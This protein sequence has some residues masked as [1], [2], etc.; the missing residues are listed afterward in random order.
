V[1]V[2][3]GIDTGGTFTDF[4]VVHEG[5][6]FVFKVPST[7]DDPARAFHEGLA[8]A[9][10][11]L[12][13]AGVDVAAT[14]PW[15]VAHGFTVAT[16]ALL[17]RKGARIAFV[18]TQGF[19]DV[20]AIGRQHRP[21]LY[22]LAPARPLPLVAR[23]AIVG[24]AERLGP[25]G[26][27]LR[28]LT[29]AGALRVARAVARLKPEAVAVGFL[30]SYASDRHERRVRAA[31]ARVLPGVPVSLSSQVANVHREVERLSTTTADAYVAPLVTRYLRRLAAPKSHALRIMQSNGG[32]LPARET[33]RRPVA[34][35]LSGPAGGVLGAHRLGLRARV[36]SLL[37]LD[38]G[39]TSTDVALV[40]GR[41]LAT[42]ETEIAGIPLAVPILDVHTVGAGGGSIARV[43]AGG[44]LVVGPESAGAAP[45]P[46]CYGRGGPATVTD[47]MVVLGRIVPERFLDGGMALDAS[48]S[49]RVMAALGRKLGTD[50][51]GAARGVVAVAN[52]TIERALRAI[53][54]ERGHDVRGAALVA[55]GGAGPLHACELAAALGAG[56]VLVPPAA[57]ILSAW[58]LLGADEVF[59]EAATLLLRVPRSS[60]WPRAVVARAIARL[61]RTLVSRHGP[62]GR[63]GATFSLRYQGQSFELRLP[64][65]VAASDLRKAFD[66]AHQERYGYARPEAAVEIV[67]IELALTRP[68]PRLPAFPILRTTRRDALLGTH[69]VALARGA[70]AAPVWRRESLGRSFAARGPL[71]VIEYGATTFVPPGWRVRVDA[72]AN[73]RLE[74]A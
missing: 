30:H 24:A 58:G 18:T 59:A 71:L 56:E 43:D 40:P 46:A 67:E 5:S 39:G 66:R 29:P 7:P 53:S 37:T 33:A 3:V 1:T 34:T 64:A 16:N 12:L 70:R 32:A 38:I 25:R 36:D 65:G 2:H 26:E 69:R 21:E 28:A 6:A 48:A 52:A 19:E 41:L 62:G 72:S 49:S 44:A 74:R 50:A 60:A 68:G 51:V 22:A 27:A 11:R 35:V 47:A 4:L 10:R 57:G 45:G 55:F 17:A 9:A 8:I 42:R 23:T 20:L 15:D 13:A 73:L 61:E 63:L 14:R 31:L 54:V